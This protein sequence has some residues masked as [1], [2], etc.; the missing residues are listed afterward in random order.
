M[1]LLEDHL[2]SN[3]KLV[4]SLAIQGAASSI[5]NRMHDLNRSENFNTMMQHTEERDTAE[6]KMEEIDVQ[7]RTMK[8]I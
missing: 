8:S 7:L 1:S 2:E 3:R 5:N 4:S 6:E